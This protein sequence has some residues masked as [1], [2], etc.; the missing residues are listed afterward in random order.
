MNRG[1]WGEE[2][3]AQYLCRKGYKILARN[4][5]IRQGEL[6]IIASK[7]KYLAFV[8]VKTRKNDRFGA[9]R[10]FIT[11]AKQRRL[12]QTAEYWC[13]THPTDLQPRFD[14]VEIYGVE[15]CAHPRINHLENIFEA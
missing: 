3:A 14:A 7:G 11:P 6:D 2:L 12:I 4:F 5:R 1:A 13:L 8:E 15:G 9:A 10:E